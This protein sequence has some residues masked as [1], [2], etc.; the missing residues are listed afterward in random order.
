MAQQVVRIIVAP[1][2]V[3]SGIE[4][5]NGDGKVRRIGVLTSGGDA[6]GMDAPVR[7]LLAP[8]RVSCS[9]YGRMGRRRY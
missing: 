1:R 9:Y 6:A 3:V 5:R 8:S 2:Y 4:N 7:A